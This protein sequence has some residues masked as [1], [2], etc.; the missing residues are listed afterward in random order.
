ME[1]D[2][3]LTQE[4]KAKLEE[5]LHYLET[6]K[7]AE[8]G[9]RI[10]VAR[11]FGD[12]SENSE[13]DDAKNEQAMMEGRIAEITRILGEATVVD[14]PTKSSKVPAFSRRGS[15]LS[16]A[17]TTSSPAPVT[18]LTVRPQYPPMLRAFF[19]AGGSNLCSVKIA[20]IKS[21]IP[22]NSALPAVIPLAQRHPP[23]Q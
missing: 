5:E 8:I 10:R 1:K 19:E 9:E 18:D 22:L 6:E 17:W 14:A 16:R 23:V 21:Q 4:G 3:I 11:E 2:Y 13:Y 7:R 15:R 20:V 12:I